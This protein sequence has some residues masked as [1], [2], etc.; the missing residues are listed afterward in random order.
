MKFVCVMLSLINLVSSQQCRSS[1]D[2][3]GAAPHC[4]KWGWCQWTTKHGVQGPSEYEDLIGEG[5]ELFQS[6]RSF[7]STQEQAPTFNPAHS[8]IKI[9][10]YAD[11]YGG[12]IYDYYDISYDILKMDPISKDDSTLDASI[13]GGN[14]K[15][16]T[17]RPVGQTAA[18]TDVGSDDTSRH[19]TR[20]SFETEVLSIS[21]GQRANNNGDGSSKSFSYAG[22]S[23]PIT[24]DERTASTITDSVVRVADTATPDGHTEPVTSEG[25]LI[26]CVNDCVA[27]EELTAYRDCVEFCGRAC[28]DS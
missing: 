23:I 27:I 9:T 14:V 15:L 21:N 26:D 19:A 10:D 7:P 6:K 18:T 4:S 28:D 17:V 5:S 8:R 1:S 12:D 22:T 24:G 2:C 13:F 3:G 11:Y 20:A 16:V 25:C